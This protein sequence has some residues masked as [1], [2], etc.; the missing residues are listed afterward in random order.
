MVFVLIAMI[1]FLVLVFT[2]DGDGEPHNLPE[3][4]GAPAGEN[5]IGQAVEAAEDR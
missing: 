4:V 5:G 2:S 1:A 3:F